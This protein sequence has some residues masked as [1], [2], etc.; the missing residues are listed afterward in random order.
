[1]RQRHLHAGRRLHAGSDHRLRPRC[2]ATSGGRSSTDGAPGQNWGAVFGNRFGKLGVD[3]QRHALLQG[4]VRRRAARAS[5]A[6]ATGDG[7]RSRSATTTCST[8]TQKAQLGVVGNV[9]YQFSPNHRAARRELLHATAG[10]DEGRIFEG[11]NTENN[12]D[13]RNYRLQFI[14]EGLMS[15]A[16]RRASTSSRA[17]ATAASTGAST[18]ARANRDEPDLREIALPGAVQPTVG[19]S[20]RRRSSLADESQSGFRMFNELDDETL[21]VAGN[22]SVF[23][24]GGG[25]ADAGQVRRQLRRSHARLPVAPV[26][27]HPDRRSTKDGA[28]A[29][30]PR[31][32]APEELLHQP[33]NIGTAFRFNEETRPVDAYDGD[34]DDDRRLRHGRRGAVGRTRLVAGARVERFD[35]TGQH[36]R[37]VRPV[38]A[39]A[40]GG[41]QEH[42]RVPRRQLRA[43]AAAEHEPAPRL[44][45]DGQ[46]ARSSASWRRS[47]SPTSS[48]AAP[49]AATR[50]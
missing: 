47:S 9:A 45:H 14:E 48:A 6:S 33:S 5:S 50:T 12:F 10:R 25:R 40:H 28:V 23:S 31:R 19:R 20:D 15:N 49:S 42:R 46:P 21:D 44:Q 18:S 29:V 38:R 13:Y 8:G 34:A 43:V 11:A 26:P 1:M 3:R 37:P 35:Q 32:S 30:Q 39:H 24:T 7:A 2:S 36:L 41:E 22:W 16:R 4:A 27:L 17:W